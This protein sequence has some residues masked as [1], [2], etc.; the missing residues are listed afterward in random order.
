MNGK[1][2]AIVVVVLGMLALVAGNSLAGLLTLWRLKLSIPLEFTTWW[3]YARALDLPRLAPYAGTIRFAGYA[4]FGLPL[5]VWIVAAVWLL[6][7]RA[8]AFHGE[9]RFA[10]R[11]DLARAGLLKQGADGVII[12][13]S[14]GR[15]L[16][17]GGLQHIIMTAPTRTGKTSSVAIP[18]LLTYGHSAVVMDLKGELFQ[19]TSGYRRSQGQ[20]IR[21]FAPYAEDGR[22][23]R[24]NPF[25][26]LSSDPRVRVS[27]IQTI[28]AILY[29]D[30]PQKD[31]FWIAQA[32]SAFLGFASFMYEQWDDR[33]G[34]GMQLDPNTD[35]SFPSFERIYRLSSG[36]GHGGDLKETIKQWLSDRAFLGEQTRTT[37]SG[38][39]GLATETFSSVIATVQEPL[40]QF[41]SPILAAA[42]NASDFDVAGLRR[43]PTTIYVVIPPAKLG[44]SGKLL[45]I[46]FS[47]VVGQNLKTTPQE[48]PSIK[49]Q[50]LLLMD[51][52]TAMGR[53]NALSERISITAGYWVRDL[54]IIQSNSQLRATYGADAAQTYVTNHAASIVFT[55]R[56]QQD[57]EDYSKM[58]GD[59]TVRR[60]Q[61]TVSK[62]GTSW[63]HTEERRPLM[64][65]QELKGLP[66]DDEI[67]FYEGCPP[68]RCRKNWYFKNAY[69][70]KRVLPPVEIRPIVPATA[71][72]RSV[73]VTVLEEAVAM[74]ALVEE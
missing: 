30:D 27:E 22:T 66:N 16:Y 53:V 50:V 55:P 61:R 11:A 44:E 71:T 52:F 20:T 3:Q 73:D 18:V 58:L 28:G 5:L 8:K 60:R 19:T 25:L 48:D 49:H 51:E 68:I 10:S 24:F 69:F 29:P 57:A 43:R 34:S 1:T 33:V 54:T 14:G 26:C 12:G 65:P 39:A 4:G 56:E 38:L 70:R 32:R 9:A 74:R 36:D 15:Y 45:N 2:R 40:Q 63:S 59:T 72:R 64:L 37:L 46:F 21:K 6:K 47:A 67:I 17:L 23:H 62:G 31:P 13:R 7:P 42:T 35:V 41:I